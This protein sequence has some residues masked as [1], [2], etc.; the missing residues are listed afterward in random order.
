MDEFERRIFGE[1]FGGNSKTDSFFEKLDKFGQTRDRVGSKSG[2]GSGFSVLDGLDES[3]NTLSDGMDGKLKE[4]A[5]YF[6]FDPEEVQKEDY[7][8]RP[9]MNFMPRMTYDTKV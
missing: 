7:A 8:F 9:D 3:F 4:A 6:E 5:T 1:N 2:E